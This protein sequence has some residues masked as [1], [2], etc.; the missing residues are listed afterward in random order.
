MNVNFNIVVCV[1]AVF[2]T[3]NT[4]ARQGGVACPQEGEQVCIT[5]TCDSSNRGFNTCEPTDSCPEPL[6][7]TSGITKKNKASSCPFGAQFTAQCALCEC[8]GTKTGDH[9]AMCFALPVRRLGQPEQVNKELPQNTDN[10]FFNYEINGWDAPVEEEED[11]EPAAD[12]P[13]QE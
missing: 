9:C 10:R 2:L 5:C 11:D 13:D 8:S 4:H 6:Q 3:S 1:V 12:E 7:S